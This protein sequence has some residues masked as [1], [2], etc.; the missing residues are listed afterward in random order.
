MKNLIKTIAT[1]AVVLASLNASAYHQ[2]DS[3]KWGMT[4]VSDGTSFVQ[5]FTNSIGSTTC[6]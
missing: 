4:T 1:T 2:I 6:Y 3:N 5:C